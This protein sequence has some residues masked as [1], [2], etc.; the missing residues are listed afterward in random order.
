MDVKVENGSIGRWHVMVYLDVY[1]LY[2]ICNRQ[3]YVCS[4]DDLELEH[5]MVPCFAPCHCLS[6][7]MCMMLSYPIRLRKEI[8][9]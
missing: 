8:S 7:Y 9:P 1:M 2:A 5:F 3:L 6:I 4:L